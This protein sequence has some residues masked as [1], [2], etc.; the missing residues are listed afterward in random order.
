MLTQLREWCCKQGIQFAEFHVPITSDGTQWDVRALFR[1]APVDFLQPYI[2]WAYWNKA[3]QTH[4]A[5]GLH[6]WVTYDM[7]REFY[8]QCPEFH[9]TGSPW[10]D[11]WLLESDA[12]NE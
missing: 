7:M 10:D 11:M 4:C 9:W 12:Q 2:V 6:S 1:Q 8:S 3:G 5:K